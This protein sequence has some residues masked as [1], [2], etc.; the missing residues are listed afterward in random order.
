[1]WQGLLR[2]EGDDGD[3][4]DDEED[5]ES[6]RLSGAIRAGWMGNVLDRRV[7]FGLGVFFPSVRIAFSDRTWRG[8][9]QGKQ[10]AILRRWLERGMV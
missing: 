7:L 9:L 8:K 5:D 4:D 1:L 10:W 3:G 2:K 6:L